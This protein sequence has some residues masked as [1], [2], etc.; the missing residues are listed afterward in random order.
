M[1]SS[2][3]QIDKPQRGR[4]KRAELP[5]VNINTGAQSINTERDSLRLG[6]GLRWPLYQAFLFFWV[7][8]ILLVLK[9][10][11]LFWHLALLTN[12]DTLSWRAFI[13]L[14]NE[15]KS[16]TLQSRLIL[17]E[18]YMQIPRTLY[19]QNWKGEGGGSVE[20]SVKSY[21]GRDGRN[22]FKVTLAAQCLKLLLT[23]IGPLPRDLPTLTFNTWQFVNTR[24][25]KRHGNK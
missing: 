25:K 20:A 16:V 10:V 24:N 21:D 5:D 15:M 12:I 18:W 4:P 22:L 14:V 13:G 7:S 8:A 17:L 1:A 19:Q 6:L 3:S 11:P 2:D 23:R 9:Y